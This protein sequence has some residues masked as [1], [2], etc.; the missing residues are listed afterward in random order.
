MIIASTKTQKHHDNGMIVQ[1]IMIVQTS[2][3][4]MSLF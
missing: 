1:T 2:M 3:I 4:R